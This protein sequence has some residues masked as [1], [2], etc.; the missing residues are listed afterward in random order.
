VIWLLALA[1]AAITIDVWQTRQNHRH[2]QV[3]RAIGYMGF[4]TPLAVARKLEVE[5]MRANQ[6]L[7]DARARGLC[8][9]VF[10]DGHITWFL[11][12]NG[13]SALWTINHWSSTATC[14]S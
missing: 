1:I 9:R 3:L 4:M 14:R 8:D 10:I 13:R 6:L 2:R 7:M 12:E 5:T 11:T